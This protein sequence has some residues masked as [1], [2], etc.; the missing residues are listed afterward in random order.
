MPLDIQ[1]DPAMQ[2]L[3]QELETSRKIV[4]NAKMKSYAIIA[5][6]AILIFIFP[7]IWGFIAGGLIAIFGIYINT[8]IDPKLTAYKKLFKQQVIGKILTGVNESMTINPEGGISETEFINSQL[9]SKKPD[10]YS[11]EDYISGVAGKTS[12]YYAEVNAEYVTESTDNK[13]RRTETWHEILRGV[14]F[15]ADFNKNFQG[16]TLVRPKDFGSSV[17]KW[18]SQALPIFGSAQSKIVELENIEFNKKFITES[19]DQIEARY[20]LTPSLMEKL[21]ALNTRFGKTISL[22]FI[23]SKVYIALPLKDNYFEPPLYSSILDLSFIEKDISIIKFLYDIVE[24]LDLNT[25]IWGK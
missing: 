4:V 10:R 2:S 6:G 24:D 20:I 8:S 14:V 17:S 21:L 5:S 23:R 19:S 22:S 16:V 12:F 18:F 7:V 15:A 11:T 9:F 13:G 1:N 25:R 3:L